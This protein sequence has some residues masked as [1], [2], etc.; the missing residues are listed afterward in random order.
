M[1]KFE[2][3]PPQIIDGVLNQQLRVA[4]RTEYKQVNRCEA[5]VVKFIWENFEK[6]NQAERIGEFRER[7]L[8]FINAL[9][10]TYGRV[11]VSEVYMSGSIIGHPNYHEHAFNVCA[12]G[13][14][15]DTISVHEDIFIDIDKDNEIVKDLVYNKRIIGLAS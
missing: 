12:K 15:I 1:H 10:K 2:Q 9:P 4:H 5:E 13:R 11:E 7:L 8:E 3:Q 6:G 14:S